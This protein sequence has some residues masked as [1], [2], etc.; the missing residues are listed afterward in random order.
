[1]PHARL[2]PTTVTS[3]PVSVCSVT[4]QATVRSLSVK[5]AMVPPAKLVSQDFSSIPRR[6]AKAA[7][8]L[9]SAALVPQF[10]HLA[11]KV[12]P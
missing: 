1:M 12:T 3:P 6:S 2:A 8:T 9:V 5:L 4:P 11:P 7:P 10:A